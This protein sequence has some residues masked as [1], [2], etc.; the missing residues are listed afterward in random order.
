M[1]TVIATTYTSSLSK[2]IQFLS[3]ASAVTVNS[4]TNLMCQYRGINMMNKCCYYN[5]ASINSIGPTDA[6]QLTS[7]FFLKLLHK[8]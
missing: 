4:L 3:L 5:L 8:F 2:Y 1:L 6:Y 7:F